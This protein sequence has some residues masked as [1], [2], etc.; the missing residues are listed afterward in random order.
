MRIE[1]TTAIII[2]EGLMAKP[3]RTAEQI[4]ADVHLQMVDE[5]E[6]IEMANDI[7]IAASVL[8]ATIKKANH[9]ASCE[10]IQRMRNDGPREKNGLREAITK[11]KQNMKPTIS[12][13]LFNSLANYTICS[14]SKEE[15]MAANEEKMACGCICAPSS[16]AETAFEKIFEGTADHDKAM[17]ISNIIEQLADE[18]LID[19][20]KGYM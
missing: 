6:D 11:K 4:L 8:F 5:L 1:E 13:K 14:C 20:K 9:K 3:Q 16:W 7:A 2:N 15:I 17:R 19:T 18:L 12:W 10:P